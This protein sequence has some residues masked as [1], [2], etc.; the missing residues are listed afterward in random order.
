MKFSKYSGCGNDFILID[1]RSH[2]FVTDAVQK[3]CDRH[4]GIGADGV[5]LLEED[6][7][8]KMRI[9]NS[10]GSQAEMCGNG[11]RCLGNF[12]LELGYPKKPYQ[13]MTME[14]TLT[15]DFIDTYV[16]AEMGAVQNLTFLEELNGYFLN[17]GVP[18]AVFFVDKLDQIDITSTGSKIRHHA[19]FAPSGT[20]VNF[21][22]R[23]SENALSIRT[24][25]RG[26][27]AETLACGTGACASATAGRLKWGMQ[28]P[29][30]VQFRSKDKLIINF[31]NDQVTQTG[32]AVKLF[33]GVF[34]IRGY[35]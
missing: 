19:Q 9:F 32:P 29:I 31:E 25:E 27:E 3:L 17:T 14:R 16:K 2:E 33:H 34:D 15:I 18:H 35:L 6:Q 7:D 28:A 22:E 10:D 13:I 4:R 1:N 23:I 21:V 11:L 5:I 24:F 8:F 30:E 20:N 26:V 12:I